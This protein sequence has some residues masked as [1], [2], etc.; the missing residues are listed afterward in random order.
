M[1][2][3]K[4][5][6]TQGILVVHG[7][8]D[9]SGEGLGEGKKQIWGGRGRT[10]RT[11]KGAQWEILAYGRVGSWR[12]QIAGLIADL[13]LTSAFDNGLI[14]CD[15]LSQCFSIQSCKHL[16]RCRTERAQFST[17]WLSRASRAPAPGTD[18]QLAE[19][20]QPPLPPP[21]PLPRAQKLFVMPTL[22]LSTH[23]ATL[24]QNV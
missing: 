3:M 7:S 1:V 20:W 22:G 24:V 2:V 19:D 5:A 23:V 12:T 9:P 13:R 11:C 4:T 6:R 8:K 18:L 15:L 10:K 14:R 16:K 21:L 17:S